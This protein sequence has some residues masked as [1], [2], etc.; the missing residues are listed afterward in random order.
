MK[1]PVKLLSIVLEATVI[2]SMAVSGCGSEKDDFSNVDNPVVTIV[3]KNMGTI[4][5]ELYPNVAPNTVKNFISLAESGF[6]DGLT[7]H[8]VISGFMVQGGD[9]QGTGNGGPG[10]FIKGEFTANGF[11]N[12]LSHTRG[13]LSM[14]RRNKPFDSAGSQFFIMHKDY[15]SLDGLYAAFG[16]VIEGIE[17][18]DMIAA[19]GTDKNDRPLTEVIIESITVDTKGIRY[20][21]PDTL[22]AN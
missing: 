22:P 15:T 5:A 4:K 13:V 10:Y 18:V 21:S 7:F 9:P 8:R 3:V 14:A 6:Y 20:G 19:V 2:L 11:E 17:V 12:N 16:K 1:R